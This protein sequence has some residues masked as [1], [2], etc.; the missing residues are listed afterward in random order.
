MMTSDLFGLD[1]LFFLEPSYDRLIDHRFTDQMVAMAPSEGRVLLDE[2]ERPLAIAVKQDLW[3]GINLIHRE[4][5]DGL[6]AMIEEM[7]IEVFQTR[8]RDYIGAVREYYSVLITHNVSP[9]G[10]DLSKDRTLQVKDLILK[11]FG[12]QKGKTCLDVGCGS[13]LGSF[14]LHELGMNAV[15]YDM[16]LALL[17]LGLGSGRLY[18]H[19]VMHIDATRADHYID[20]EPFGMVLMAGK[21][22][23]F[24]SFLW[25]Q[26]I[27]RTLQLSENTLITVETEMEARMVEPWCGGRKVEVFENERDPFYDRWVVLAK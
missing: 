10:E 9:A 3:Y 26:I 23:D 5:T 8:R 14:A 11:S 19:E 22:G 24:N 2:E 27:E 6:I 13:G 25:K 16:D 17:S 7:E 4:P 15:S 12:R 21:I 18:F 1:E 20:P